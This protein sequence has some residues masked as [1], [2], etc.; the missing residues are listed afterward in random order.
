MRR[1]PDIEETRGTREEP[2][3]GK[4]KRKKLISTQ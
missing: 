2:A 3:A 4:E 1:A